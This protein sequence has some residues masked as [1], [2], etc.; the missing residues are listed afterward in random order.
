MSDRARNLTVGITALLGV[1]GVVVMMMLFGYAPRWFEDN[2][3]VTIVMNSA[4][5]LGK[6]SRVLMAGK[7]VGRIESVELTGPPKWGVMVVAAVDSK[8]RLPGQI[9]I[10]VESPILGGSPALTLQPRPQASQ[11]PIIYLPSDG[12]ARIEIE[13]VPSLL[14]EFAAELRSALNASVGDLRIELRK[15][16]ANLDALTRT[17]VT[18]GTNLNELIRPR[19]P[20]TVDSDET[21]KTQGN[22][23]TM[24]ARADARLRQIE[25]VIEDMKKWVGDHE[26]RTRIRSAVVNTDNLVKTADGGVGRLV[27]AVESAGASFKGLSRKYTDVADELALAIQSLRQV[28]MLAGSGQ[29]TVGKA[30]KDPAIFDNVNDAFERLSHTLDE[31]RMLVEK[32]QKEGMPLKF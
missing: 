14:S 20:Q 17:W 23:A 31:M 25:S 26:L 15:A 5:G 32:W 30:L 12:S 4:G 16:Q 27:A 18:V 3:V 24:V 9:K 11:T 8:V 1:A 7:N 28:I 2:Y 10:S 19:S 21:G 13:D 22:V 6:G 29:G